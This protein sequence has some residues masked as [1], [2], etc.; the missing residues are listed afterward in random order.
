VG[1]RAC[2]PCL[3][4]LSISGVFCEQSLP[5]FSGAV[6]VPI[7]RIAKNGRVAQQP[8][9]DKMPM[10][11]AQTPTQLSLRLSTKPKLAQHHHRR[12]GNPMTAAPPPL[13]CRAGDQRSKPRNQSSRNNAT[14]G[15]E[16]TLRQLNTPRL[17]MRTMP[18]PI[19]T[20]HTQGEGE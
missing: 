6:R 2:R 14:G 18:E 11:V 1:V 16:T 4:I 5:L 15:L 3:G 13:V 8:E 12:T 9:M 7:F 20:G 10:A 19:P 17:P